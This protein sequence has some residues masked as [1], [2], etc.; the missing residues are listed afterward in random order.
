MVE[1]CVTEPDLL[2]QAYAQCGALLRIEDRDR[3]LASLFVPDDAR[4]HLWALYAFNVEIA[5]VRD[6]VRE[7]LPG[8]VRFQWWREVIEGRGRGDVDAHPVALALSRTLEVLELP[9]QALLNLIDARTFD[10]YDD[11]MPSLND[12]EGYAGE[13]ASILL[14]LGGQVLLGRADPALADPAGHG[15]VA[16][17]LTGLMRALP[18]HAARGQCYLPL[19][20][21]HAQGI[22]REE[23]VSGTSSAALKAVLSDLRGV[24]Q[25]HLDTARAGLAQVPRAAL[26]VFLPLALVPKDLRALARARD[27]FAPGIGAS[28]LTRLWTLW[29]A[30]RRS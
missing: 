15:G 16:L 10:L 25:G 20:R 13:T 7:A 4:R 5:R 9:R 28:P 11:P 27:P 26:P 24:A 2:R 19:D 21:L 29:W 30:A 1:T 12:L 22:G 3:F 14:Q 18:I 8:E 17:A 23:V 6:V